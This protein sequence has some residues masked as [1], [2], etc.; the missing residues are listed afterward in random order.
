MKVRRTPLLLIV[1]LFDHGLSYEA[2]AERTHDYVGLG[3]SRASIYVWIAESQQMEHQGAA[4]PYWVVERQAHFHDLVAEARRVPDIWEI[5]PEPLPAP[6]RDPEELFAERARAD[7]EA[8]EEAEQVIEDAIV[9]HAQRDDIPAAELRAD[10][11]ELRE[12]AR[13]WA[14]RPKTP[15]RVKEIFGRSHPQDPQERVTGQPPPKSVAEREREHPRA[16]PEGW[17]GPPLQKQ[18]PPVWAKPKKI[19]G[20]GSGQQAPP[21]EGR[22][23]VSTK[24]YSLAERRAGTVSLDDSGIKRW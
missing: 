2:V 23:L 14:A 6:E 4:S 13:E 17:S 7:D 5:E 16:C 18:K 12:F 11:Q 3:C 24:S 10:I 21:A 19:E 9:E 8:K 15:G 20:P 22:F 1:Q